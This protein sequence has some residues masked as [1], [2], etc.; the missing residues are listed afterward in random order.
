MMPNQKNR[1]GRAH[2]RANSL[3][4]KPATIGT[5]SGSVWTSYRSDPWLTAPTTY[6][7]TR[8]ARQ[9]PPIIFRPFVIE[10]AFHWFVLLMLCVDA[11]FSGA[12]RT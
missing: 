10:N 9:Q 8:T 1:H 5:H 4:L 6:S 11:Y 7:A 2:Q 12:A 3:Q